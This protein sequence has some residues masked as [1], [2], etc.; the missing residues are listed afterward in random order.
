MAKNEKNDV[1][2]EKVETKIQNE[3]QN[4]EVKT[5][6]KTD[7]KSEEQVSTSPTPVEENKEVKT[8]ETEK[9]DPKVDSKEA[10]VTTPEVLSTQDV[11]ERVGKY[12]MYAGAEYLFYSDEEFEAFKKNKDL[13]YEAMISK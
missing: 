5:E 8:Q 1:K 13:E 6:S 12:Y 11:G 9:V 7:V 10:P 4:E 3:I 2:N